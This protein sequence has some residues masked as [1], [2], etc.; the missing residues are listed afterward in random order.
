MTAAPA[1][2]LPSFLVGWVFNGD[3]ADNAATRQI[4]DNKELQW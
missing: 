4:G 3:L 1:L 2:Y